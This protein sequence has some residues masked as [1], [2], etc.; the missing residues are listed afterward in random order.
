MKT[1]ILGDSW[2]DPKYL[3]QVNRKEWVETP[4]DFPYWSERFNATNLSSV[5][6]S[7]DH[8]FDQFIQHHDKYNTV[9]ILW[10][11]WNRYGV[12]SYRL[13]KASDVESCMRT[14]NYIEAVARIR[15][16][17]LSIQGCDPIELKG[18]FD[19]WF[20]KDYRTFRK[21][22]ITTMLKRGCIPDLHGTPVFE[23]L[24]GFC[25]KDL[26][27][28]EFGSDYRLHEEFDGHPNKK[29]HDFIYEYIKRHV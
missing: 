27:Q 26:L 18:E 9:I 22:T 29:G 7:N 3:P 13:G 28:R 25:M 8:I 17:A 12:G 10:S 16:D 6:C 15:P 14:V 23:E 2:S 21:L 4:F 1:L 24:R 11:S 5:G 19:E 20:H